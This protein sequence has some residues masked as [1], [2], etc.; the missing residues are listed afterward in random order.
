MQARI[1]FAYQ[2]LH[3]RREP[4][5]ITRRHARQ[6]RVLRRLVSMP[7]HP[8]DVYRL[9][10]RVSQVAILRVADDAHDLAGNAGGGDAAAEGPSGP[11]GGARERRGYERRFRWIGR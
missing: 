9:D 3:D 8:W 6:E 1:D 4:K 10:H 7:L 11:E 5:R 2:P